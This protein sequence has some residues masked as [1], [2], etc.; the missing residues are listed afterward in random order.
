MGI[1]GTLVVAVVALASLPALR[2]DGQILDSAS[3]AGRAP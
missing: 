2:P 1:A 3:H